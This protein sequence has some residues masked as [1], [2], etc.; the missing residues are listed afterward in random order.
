MSPT[1]SGFLAGLITM[2]FG[3]IGCCFARFWYLNRDPL[4]IS[5]ALAFWLLAANQ[6]LVGLSAVPREEQSWIYLLR[7][8][9]FLII[10]FAIVK[11]NI[12]RP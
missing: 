4:F 9:A 7:I 6:M 10:A 8:A 2:C 1:L 12:R 11:K 5:F 3:A